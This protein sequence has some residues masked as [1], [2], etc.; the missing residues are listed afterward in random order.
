MTESA[1]DLTACGASF[2]T[3]VL[4]LFSHAGSQRR[5]DKNLFVNYSVTHRSSMP[6]EP[7]GAS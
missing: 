2:A 5:N 7:R 4:H 3:E 1:A 6:G